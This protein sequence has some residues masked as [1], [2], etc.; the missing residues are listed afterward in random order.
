MDQFVFDNIASEEDTT[1]EAVREEI[2]K[3]ILEAYNNP[4]PKVKEQWEALFGSGV[5]P[6]PEQ[7]L[8]VLAKQIRGVDVGDE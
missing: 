1:P 7:L 4:D 8:E 6:K 3:A 5:V 2:Q